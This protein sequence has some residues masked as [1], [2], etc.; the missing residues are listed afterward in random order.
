M[1]DFSF[2]TLKLVTGR[3]RLRQAKIPM[4]DNDV[5]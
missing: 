5:Y 3:D 1:A 4:T 2:P